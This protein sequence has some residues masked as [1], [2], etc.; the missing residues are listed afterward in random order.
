MSDEF[1][2]VVSVE[3]KSDLN[4]QIS[5]FPNPSKD[6]FSVKLN[7]IYENIEF[8]IKDLNGRIVISDSINGVLEFSV[9]LSEFTNGI[10]LLEINADK[11]KFKTTLIKE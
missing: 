11:Q 8:N 7:N 4:S 10:Y 6:R 3:D 2:I 1:D 5:V 9:N